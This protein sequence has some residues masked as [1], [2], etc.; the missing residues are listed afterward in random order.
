MNTKILKVA[1]AINLALITNVSAQTEA[2]EEITVKGHRAY[3]SGF[4][5]LET[6]SSES[7]LDAELLGYAGVLNLDQALDLSA[8]VARQNNFGGLWNSFS[9]R[10]FSGDINLPSG[11]LVNGFNAGRGFGG[12]RDIIGVESVEVLRGPRSALFG[13]GEPGGTVNLTTKRPQFEES[14]E[15][16]AAVGSWDQVRVTGDW[17]TTLGEEENVGLRL[18][19]F[20]EDAESFRETV[21]TEKVGFYP[22]VSWQASDA[23]NITESFEIGVKV[24]LGALGSDIAGTLNLA[25]FQVDQ[26]NILVNDDRPEAVAAGFF[27]ASAGEA[28]SQGFE[29][30]ANLQFANDIS[31]WVSYAYTDAVFTTTNPDADFGAIIEVGDQLFNSPENQLSLQLNKGLY[32]ANMDAQVGVGLLYTDERAGFTGFDFNL[33]SYTTTRLFAELQP[34][35]RF[36]V[37]LDVDN[38]FDERDR[39]AR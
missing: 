2:L 5:T 24:D 13:R 1:A 27:S 4:D 18:V 39:E 17:Q 28:Q 26:S 33:P 19:G 3:L 7:I 6:P 25:A 11:F 15:F 38:L 21:E 23:T 14:G 34:S 36:S 35:E 29:L 22:S 20:I 37:R 12:P 31:L 32:L 10:G 9:V 8:S 16:Q 30:D